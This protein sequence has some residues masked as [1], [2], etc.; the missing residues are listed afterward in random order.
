VV[1][2]IDPYGRI[3]GFLDRNTRLAFLNYGNAST[4]TETQI[5]RAFFSGSTWTYNLNLIN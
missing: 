3:L 2:A 5:Y 1:S 4:Q